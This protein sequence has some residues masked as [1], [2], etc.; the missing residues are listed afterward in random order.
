MTSGHL[1]FGVITTQIGKP[2]LDHLSEVHS[3]IDTN[4]NPLRRPPT[5]DPRDDDRSGFTVR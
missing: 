4:M 3:Q 2:A 1:R 5:R